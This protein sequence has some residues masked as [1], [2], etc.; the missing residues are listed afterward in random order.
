MLANDLMEAVGRADESSLANLAAIC[1]YVYNDIPSNAHG[2]YERVDMHQAAR[3]DQTETL[4]D[5]VAGRV[6]C[7]ESD[8]FRA[9]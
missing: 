9:I 2:S 6:A 5:Q 1:R 8:P 4:T 7:C 3:R